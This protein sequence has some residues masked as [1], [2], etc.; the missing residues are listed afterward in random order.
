MWQEPTRLVT[1]KEGDMPG[2][3][4]TTTS[5]SYI[6]KG[7]RVLVVNQRVGTCFECGRQGHYKKKC[8]K[9]RN[10]NRG[11][12]SGRTEARVKAY[13]IGGGDANPDSNVVTGTVLLNNRYAS[14]LFDSGADRSFVSTTFSALLYVIPSTLDISYAVEL[15]DG[16]VTETN[17]VL[18]GCTL[19]FLG[20]PFNINLIPIE[21]GSFNVIIGMDWLAN[22]HAV[23]VC[24]E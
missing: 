24:D 7:H 22:H 3:G 16:R 4:L 10:Q 11:N 20:H 23:I 17:T 5:V 18:R 2:L 8:P 13:A 12:K 19:G 6:T 9:S 15:I 1:M 21:V 14:M